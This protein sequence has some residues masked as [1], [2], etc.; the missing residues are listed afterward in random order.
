MWK[1]ER[2]FDNVVNETFVIYANVIRSSH[3]REGGREEE[4][5]F[6]ELVHCFSTIFELVE[7][8][9]RHRVM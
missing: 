6:Q 9:K 2:E 7:L 4:V 3:A 1:W 5:V 8:P